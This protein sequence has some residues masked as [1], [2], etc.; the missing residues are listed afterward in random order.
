MRELTHSIGHLYAWFRCLISPMNDLLILRTYGRHEPGLFHSE[1][2]AG[3][4][5]IINGE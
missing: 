4:P 5:L 2:L 3:N 1:F